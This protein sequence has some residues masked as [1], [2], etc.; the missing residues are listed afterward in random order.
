M[1]KWNALVLA[2]DSTH[3]TNLLV[4]LQDNRCTAYH[5]NK[6]HRKIKNL[7]I[8]LDIDLVFL[9]FAYWVNELR[10]VLHILK[11]PPKLVFLSVQRERMKD[12]LWDEFPLHL[13]E[14]YCHNEVKKL[15]ERIE[16]TSVDTD[17][18]FLIIRYERRYRKIPF[19]NIRYLSFKNGYTTIHTVSEKY[20]LHCSLQKLWERLPEEQFLRVNHKLILSR[21]R[22]SEVKQGFVVFEHKLVQISPELSGDSLQKTI[23]PFSSSQLKRDKKLF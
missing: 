3:T 12:Y 1:K 8:D 6:D 2:D 18:Q 9:Q 7:V 20:M 11:D 19:R 22:L 5:V 13:K 21:S 14:P 23:E 15:F 10:S 16:T 17:F 4:K